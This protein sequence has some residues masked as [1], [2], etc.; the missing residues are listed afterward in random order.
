VDDFPGF[1]P[2]NPH[3]KFLS[4]NLQDIWLGMCT[5]LGPCVNPNNTSQI[6]PSSSPFNARRVTYG[7]FNVNVTTLDGG[8]FSLFDLSGSQS[9]KQL[10]EIRS[11]SGGDPPSTVRIAIVRIQ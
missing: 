1:T 5:D 3:L 7:N 8:A 10:I 9:S 11:V 2:A 6:Y 4:W